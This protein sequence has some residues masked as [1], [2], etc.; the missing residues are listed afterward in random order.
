[1]VEM[2]R[3]TIDTTILALAAIGLLDSIYLTY[4][5][6]AGIPAACPAIGIINCNNVLNSPYAVIFG[7]PIA[8]YGLLFFIFEFVLLYLKR[9]DIATYYN[10]IGI[11]GVVYF[12]YLEKLIGSICVYCTLV[13][14][15]VVCLLILS[16]YRHTVTD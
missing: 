1:M 13:H 2:R 3:K 8:V 5:H 14:V 4:V 10:G 15:I 11:A 12:L 6:Y 9:Y 16:V 7:I